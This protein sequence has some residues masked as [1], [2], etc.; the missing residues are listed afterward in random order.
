M[1]RRNELDAFRVET[2]TTRC[3]RC[4]NNCLLTINKFP[5]GTR[6]ITG[7]RCEKGEGKEEITNDIPNLYQYKYK[8][9]FDYEPV[10]EE[11][12]R[13][14][15]GIPRVLNMYENYPFW[16]IF[17]RAGLQSSPFSTIEQ[18]P[19]LNGNGHYPIGYGLLS[20]QAGSRSYK[21]A[22]RSRCEMDF[23]P[24]I[25]YER[26]DDEGQPNH[27]NCPIVAIS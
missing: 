4:E 6:L 11:K 5:D 3:K 20:G 18:K 24:C 13:G 21:V 15:V 25:N 16:H 14:V 12:A 17:Y 22:D 2:S 23:Y 9:L 10:P 27:Y 1:L 8:R 26:N 19:V 7:N